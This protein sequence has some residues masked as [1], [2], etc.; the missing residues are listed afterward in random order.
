MSLIAGL[1]VL[2]ILLFAGPAQAAHVQCGDVI[3][4]DTVLDSDLVDCPGDGL[5]VAADGVTI[6]LSGHTIDGQGSGGGIVA[7]PGVA[8]LTITGGTVREFA[9][10]VF[11]REGEGLPEGDGLTI[12]D[13]TIEDN[14]GW[15][16][17]CEETRD[18]VLRRAV[19]RDN[20]HDGL[21]LLF[22]SGEVTDSV[23]TG[24]GAGVF[25]TEGSLHLVADN[26]IARN[27]VGVGGQGLEV[28]ER[29]RI[30]DNLR[31]GISMSYAD[32]TATIRNNRITGNLNGIAVDGEAADVTGNLIANNRRDG[33]LAFSDDHVRLIRNSILENGEYGFHAARRSCFDAVEQ[34]TIE[35][36]GT[37]GV[38]FDTE[39]ADCDAAHEVA[40]ND[41]D[42]NG[43]DGIA[44]R[45]T[46]L[47][48][49]IEGNRADRN[50]DDGI[51]VDAP[52]EGGAPVT[53]ARN[54]ADHNG[55]FGIEAYPGV[56]DGGGNRARHNGNPAQCLNVSC[57]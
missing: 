8:G 18:C 49:L 29:N 34:N 17:L 12:A 4:A 42:R 48:L 51:D 46:F 43:G 32:R 7:A 6:D 16:V 2:A 39:E 33:V 45:N 44:A 26:I 30:A 21:W 53:V 28:V 31:E 52:A 13:A 5:T 35:R 56:I 22:S 24:N 23:L 11:S 27:E 15:G 20:E 3:T 9:D 57:R 25:V 38:F 55:D 36:N 10:G 37:G 50:A 47:P 19:V 54:R 40:R 1:F 14:S 41:V